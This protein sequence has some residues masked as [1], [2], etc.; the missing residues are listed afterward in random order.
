VRGLVRAVIGVLLLLA[1]GA[2]LVAARLLRSVGTPEFKTAVEEQAGRVVGARVRIDSLDAS[3]LR[4]FRLKGVRIQNPPGFRGDL[5]SATE[6]RLS[7]DLW[8]LLLGRIQVDE[9]MLRAPVIALATDARGRFNYQQLP[10]LAPAKKGSAPK[11]LPGIS[12][13]KLEVAEAR[14]VLADERGADV[15]RFEGAGMNSHLSLTSGG[16]EGAG[17]AAIDSVVI[18]NALHLRKVQAPLTLSKERMSLN[19][20]QAA[21]AGGTA[22]GVIVVAFEPEMR[23]ALQAAVSGASVATLLKEAGSAF[24]LTG[25]LAAQAKV[26]GTGGVT[27]LRGAGQAEIEECRWPKAPLLQTLAELLQL[28]E[29]KDPRFDE[30]RIEFTLGG[31]VAR[32]PVVSFKG[33]ALELTGDGAVNL[34]SST[35]DYDL[36]LALAHGLVARI[37]AAM[38]TGFKTRAD[39]FGTIPFKVTGTTAAPRTD[40][41][42]R[43]GKTVAIEA[44]K[45]G[46]LD[47]F[48]GPKKKPQ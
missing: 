12:I 25:T 19:P 20:L 11:A 1:L 16:P 31:G 24:T 41:A 13:S 21:L 18:A 38:R 35:I 2:G 39:G 33:P 9:L 42:A 15:L 34:G 22:T 40:L 17:K 6:A 26:A 14:F 47:R 29:I 5:L 36:T 10:G 7:Y 27:T 48:F 23:Y 45:K 3:L 46:L 28:P 4:G 37:P 8:P 43:F 30:C 44:A 32:T